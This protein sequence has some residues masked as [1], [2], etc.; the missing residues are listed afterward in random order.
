MV[1]SLFN[2]ALSILCWNICENV[3]EDICWTR[4]PYLNRDQIYNLLSA[5]H[6]VTSACLVA[7]YWAFDLQC[8]VFLMYYSQAYFLYDMKNHAWDTIYFYHHIG[9]FLILL[10]LRGLHV[11]FDNYHDARAII[12]SFGLAELSNWAMYVV[13]HKLHADSCTRSFGSRSRR[14]SSFWVFLELVGYWGIRAYVGYHY[15]FV[16]P[17]HDNI[18]RIAVTVLWVMSIWWGFG[19][20]KTLVKNLCC[21]KV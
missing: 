6:S 5:F 8:A 12:I 20:A 3:I 19:F 17:V 15:L 9:S 13:Y 21:N 4:F 14:I 10:A 11:P 2:L 7:A 1:Y 18:I 16:D